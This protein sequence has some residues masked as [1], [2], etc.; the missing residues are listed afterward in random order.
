[1]ALHSFSAQPPNRADFPDE[2]ILKSQFKMAKWRVTV[3]HNTE[4]QLLLKQSC[5][6]F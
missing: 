1:M 3:S 2:I 6:I 4:E 5:L